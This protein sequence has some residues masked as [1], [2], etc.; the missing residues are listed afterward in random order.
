M[1]PI[2]RLVNK[3][4]Q[5]AIFTGALNLELG[6]R[7][8]RFRLE[9]HDS[10][11]AQANALMHKWFSEISAELKRRGFKM[12]MLDVKEAL[13]NEFLGMRKQTIYDLATGQINKET[14]VPRKTSRLNKSECYWFMS[15]VREWAFDKEIEL[16]NPED[17]IYNQW[18]EEQNR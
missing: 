7:L 16:T 15:Q 10:R 6:D 14:F 11:S 9:E 8:Y 13:K 3:R 18:R 5:Q 1:S 12:S 2:E 17:S 4:N